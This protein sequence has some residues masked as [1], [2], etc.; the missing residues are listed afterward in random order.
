M[1]MSTGYNIRVTFLI[2]ATRDGSNRLQNVV[3]DTFK[4]KIEDMPTYCYVTKF[5]VKIE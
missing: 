3:L 4:L 1:E 2:E 5:Q